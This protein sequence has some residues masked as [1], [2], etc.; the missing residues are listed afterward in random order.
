M[1]PPHPDYQDEPESYF[2]HGFE[3]QQQQPAQA[4]IL[5]DDAEFFRPNG[6]LGTTPTPNAVPALSPVPQAPP[7]SQTLPP[8]TPSLPLP[9]PDAAEQEQ[10]YVPSSSPPQ[11]TPLDVRVPSSATPS[12]MKIPKDKGKEIAREKTK[13]Q[14]G[15]STET[16]RAL[17]ESLTS[18]LGKRSVGSM[19]DLVESAG[20]A[21]ESVGVGVVAGAGQAARAGKRQRPRSRGSRVCSHLS[22]LLH[23]TLFLIM[24]LLFPSQDKVPQPTSSAK[25]HQPHRSTTTS[26][27]TPNP[28]LSTPISP[29]PAIQKTT[30]TTTS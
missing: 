30:T 10:D 22:N 29:W 7:R 26:T 15:V 11:G 27:C 21:G 13:E 1:P 5:P 19:E 8:L 16:A 3:Q 20:G 9:A 24:H 23:R 12:P 25:T 4:Q 18:L 28:T 14:I 2:A 17:Q 6:L